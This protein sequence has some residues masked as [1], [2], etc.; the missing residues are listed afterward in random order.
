MATNKNLHFEI[1][2]RKILLRIFDF[3]FVLIALA[4]ISKVSSFDYFQMTEDNFYWTFVLALYLSFFASIFE[5][6]N[7]QT[8]S[9]QYESIRSILLTTITTV[10]CY[11][12]TPYL[13]PSL[14]NNRFQLLY[15]ALTILI[16]L[17]AWRLFYIKFL[18]SQRFAKNV[19]LICDASQLDELVLSLEKVDPNYRIIRY[20]NTQTDLQDVEITSIIKSITLD[21]LDGYSKRNKI[22]EVVVASQ[23]AESITVDIYNKLIHL[24]E[25]GIPIREFTQVYEEMTYRVPVHYLERDF[26]KYFPFSRNNHNKL[27][28]LGS[29]MLDLVFSVGGL[30]LGLLFSPFIIIGNFIGNRGPLFYKQQRVGLNGKVFEIL[31]FRSMV[32]NAEA[33]GAVFAVKNDMRVTAFGKFLRKTRLDEFPQFINILKGDMA[34][35]GPRPERPFFVA[36]ISNVM[37]FYETRHI[38][39]PGLTGWAQVNYSYG[40]SIDESLIKLQYDLFYIK[41]RSL[42]LDLNI[43]IKTISTVLFYRGH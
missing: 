27:Y 16:T 28:R 14:P 3:S 36:E 38:I 18:A 17:L 29:R 40:E 8:A 23:H 13:T 39:K 37:P 19:L 31:K 26:Y 15:F 34:V 32:V 10:I 7:L 2:E 1:S 4:I 25:K 9:N 43:I 20:I 6:Y 35:I 12:L 41:H 24:L 42:F 22:S 5:L 21:Q 30:V 33:E 11:L